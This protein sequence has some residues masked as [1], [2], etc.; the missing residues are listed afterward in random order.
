MH[1]APIGSNNHF[2]LPI[3]YDAGM[4][5]RNPPPPSGPPARRRRERS[6]VER[7][8]GDRRAWGRLRMLEGEGVIVLDDRRDPRSRSPIRKIAVSPGGVF[9]LDARHYKGLVHTR[10]SGPISDLGPDELH[11]GRRDCT[12]DVERI[13]HQMAL[14]RAALGAVPGGSEVPVHAMLCLT[15]AEWGVASP[16]EIREVCVGWPQLVAGRVHAGGVMDPPTV[17]AVSATIAERL[18]TA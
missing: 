10:R 17:R 16:V 4:A 3:L 6:W 7:A 2:H 12:A 14:V 18:P 8:E 15:R 11:V 9:V 13:A 5:D 1:D